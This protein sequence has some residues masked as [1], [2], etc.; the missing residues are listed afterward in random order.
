MDTTEITPLPSLNRLSSSVFTT[1][2]RSK[3]IGKSDFSLNRIFHLEKIDQGQLERY[4]NF[5]GFYAGDASFPLSYLYLM[6][7]PAQA[8]LMLDKAFPLPLP[9]IVHLNNRLSLLSSIDLN[10]S[11]TLKVSAFIEA[12]PEGSL[13]PIVTVD[14]FQQEE[15]IATCESGYFVR[16]KSSGKKKKRKAEAFSFPVVREELWNLPALTGKEYARLSGDTNP[17]H[18]S[19]LFARLA[20]FKRRIIHGWYSLSRG[21]ATI[22][23]HTGEQFRAISVDFKKPVLL[24]GDALFSFGPTEKNEVS[25]QLSD[26]AGDLIFLTGKVHY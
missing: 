9:G 1:L 19:G 12:K 5:F 3:Q 22:E 23:K 14:F 13:F 15:K 18:T 20:G 17:I 8:A 7:Q 11:F 16:R 24:P 6:A 25:F 4:I 26:E 2:F 10:K 21:V